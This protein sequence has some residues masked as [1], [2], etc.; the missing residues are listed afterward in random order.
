[1]K[2]TSTAILLAVCIACAGRSALATMMITEWA[3]Q[4]AGG[5]YAE[6]TNT[7]GSPVDMTGWSFD[8]NSQ[9]PGS[10][11]L[12]GFGIVAPGES[13][14]LTDLTAAAFRTEWGLSAAAKVI[15]ENTQNLGR[16]DEIN[17]YDS[18]NALVDRLT[19]DDQ[20]IG[21]PR[22]NLAS[23][24]PKTL[25][26]VGTN[27]VL[28]WVLSTVGDTYGSYA[29][30]SGGTGNPGKFTLVP[31]PASLLIL[32]IA[33]LGLVPLRAKRGVLTR[34]LAIHL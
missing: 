18:A 10:V 26:V 17:L 29:S 24:N 3:Y 27:N 31:E 4:G 16:A 13:V 20:L 25:S 12:S 14:I 1:M 32:V 34:R 30:V 33:M 23:G 15:G 6:F 9:I 8:D 5:E 21:G 22:T 19:Y 28:Q 11:S 2:S 7:G